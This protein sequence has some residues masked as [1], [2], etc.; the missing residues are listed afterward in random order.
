ML[1]VFFATGVALSLFFLFHHFISSEQGHETVAD[2][3][4]EMRGL[5]AYHSEML[6]ASKEET[7]QEQDYLKVSFPLH[8][9]SN[10]TRRVSRK[11]AGFWHLITERQWGNLM[12]S[13]FEMVLEREDS[14]YIGFGEWIGPSLLYAMT[15]SR[16]AFGIEP[17]P[18]AYRTLRENAQLNRDAL[19]FDDTLV[20]SQICIQPHAQGENVT[21]IGSS[22]SMS[23]HIDLAF[24]RVEDLQTQ[25]QVPCFSFPIFFQHVVL[26]HIQTKK[27]QHR[28]N[29]K[30]ARLSGSSF[31]I[32][33]DIEGGEEFLMT[34]TEMSQWL[35][36]QFYP[37]DKPNLKISLHGS[38]HESSTVPI[39]RFLRLY[40][41]AWLYREFSKVEEL[42][43]E[44]VD[45]H[46]IDASTICLKEC[47][48]D[49]LLTDVKL[50]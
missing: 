2:T 22:D 13:Q 49:I 41:Y 1:R 43:Y 50:T 38:F 34:D 36:S 26:P 17:Q 5:S 19:R 40:R 37:H 33:I 29:H 18:D 48:C 24:R 16:Y 12:W 4:R 27:Q 8:N 35:L 45:P 39:L 6:Q 15:W 32:K 21:F 20:L 30:V 9:Q 10:V 25:F 47:C 44:Q 14:I 31:L 11:H 28:N 3:R 7:K 46:F 23:R 42:M